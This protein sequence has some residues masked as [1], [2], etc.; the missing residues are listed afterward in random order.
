M[1]EAVAS[2]LQISCSKRQFLIDTCSDICVFPCSFLSPRKPDPN[3]Q[4]K[5]ANNSTIKT[6][7]FLMLSLDLELRRHFSWRFVVSDVPSSIIGSDFFDHFGRLPNCKHELLLHRIT[8]L[9]VRG[10]STSHSTLNIKLISGESTSYDHILKEYPT[11]TCPA[12]TIRNDS[13]ST[14]L[15]IRT[16]SGPPVFCRPRQITPERMLNLKL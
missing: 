4:L 16:T 13:H 12:G 15:H 14:F 8:S 10:R 3:F 5:T 2:L 9:S 11:I 7:G 6:Y 1:F